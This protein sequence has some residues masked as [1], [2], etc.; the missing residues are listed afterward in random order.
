MRQEKSLRIGV[1]H[2]NAVVWG[3]VYRTHSVSM[4]VRRELAVLLRE[5]VRIHGEDPHLV[6]VLREL[7]HERRVPALGRRRVGAEA[8]D[9]DRAHARGRAADRGR[10]AAAA[11]AEELEEEEEQRDDDDRGEGDARARRRRRGR[12]GR[13]A[14]RERHR[15]GRR[16]R[17]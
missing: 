5:R 2:A 16:A 3:P 6:E 13:P 14:P 11:A 17:V 12:G 7:P 1:H 4:L 9:R 15:F 10:V 8:V